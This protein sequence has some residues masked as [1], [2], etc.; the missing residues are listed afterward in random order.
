MDWDGALDR[1]QQY[2]GYEVPTLL[3]RDG[4]H[5]SYPTRYHNDYSDEAL[6]H[7]GYSLRNFLTL[8]SYAEVV[9]RLHGE[10]TT[11]HGPPTTD[12]RRSPNT[13]TPQHPNTLL[14]AQAPPLPAPSGDV[15]RAATVEELTAAVTRVRPRGTILLADGH[16]VMPRHFEIKT[17]N[18]TLRSASGNREAVRLDGLG[19]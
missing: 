6:S 8:M 16:Y 17:D 1:F 13:P 18:V 2:E 9:R 10:T 5:P 4:V 3:S 14:A 12:E 15:I 7:S 19:A 11:D